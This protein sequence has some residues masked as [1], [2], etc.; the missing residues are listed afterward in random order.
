MS[1]NYEIFS[2]DDHVPIL[3]DNTH[4]FRIQVS[5]KYYELGFSDFPFI[6]GRKVVLTRLKKALDFLPENYGF[7]IWDIYRPRSVQE[8]LF[9]WMRKEI[10]KKCRS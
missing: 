4:H 2:S 5:P 7:L 9:N 6:Y 1:S 10:Q 8:K 3:F